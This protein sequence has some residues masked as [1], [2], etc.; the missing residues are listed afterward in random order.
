MQ[1]DGGETTERSRGTRAATTFRNDPIASA[2]KKAMPAAARAIVLARV[3]A[4]RVRLRVD[5]WV[6]RR[7]DRHVRDHREG[8]D[9]DVVAEVRAA[10]DDRPFDRPVVREIDAVRRVDA[11]LP[12]RVVREDDRVAR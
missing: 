9:G 3:A 7:A 1:A 8:L 2:G 6:P 5:V 10:A 12:D 11:A 4:G